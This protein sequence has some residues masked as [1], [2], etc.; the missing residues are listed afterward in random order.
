MK[1]TW[2]SV[3]EI[4]IPSQMHHGEVSLAHVE[5]VAKAVEGGWDLK[6][7]PPLLVASTTDGY[8]VLDGRHR[9]YA[10]IQA[11][12]NE[13]PVVNRLAMSTADYS[14]Y[15]RSVNKYRIT[16]L[17][18]VV[19]TQGV[20]MSRIS[21]LVSDLR[22]ML[23]AK[24]PAKLKGKKLDAEINRL[25][26]IHGDRVLVNIMDLGKISNAAKAAYEAGEDMEAAIKVAIAKYRLN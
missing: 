7:V 20:A 1:P 18:S 4:K 2:V 15:R 21:E 10:A 25:Y 13:V 8:E 3:K 6:Q 26:G 23:E 16:K 5:L 22:D 14:A 19:E 12:M 9:Y 17:A 11:G 24:A